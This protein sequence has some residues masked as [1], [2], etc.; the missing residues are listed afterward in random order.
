MKYISRFGTIFY[1]DIIKK[2]ENSNPKYAGP[3]KK[4]IVFKLSK[5]RSTIL[6]LSLF[7][8]I[9]QFSSKFK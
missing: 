3:V 2:L 1:L 6:L 4:I 5:I 9:M 7:T 8:Q